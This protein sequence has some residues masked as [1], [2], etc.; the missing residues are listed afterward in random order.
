MVHWTVRPAHLSE[1]D[2]LNSLIYASARALS[3]SDYSFQQIEGLLQFVFGVDSELIHD[4]TYF[5]VEKEGVVVACG[6][7][8]KRRTLFGG[9]VCKTRDSGY[10]DPSKDAAKIRAFF[11][12]PDFSRQG[13][14]KLLI[15]HCEKAAKEFGFKKMELMSTVPGI[16]FY[17][18]QGYRGEQKINYTLPSGIVIELLPLYKTL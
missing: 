18:S 4:Q 7:W 12:H 17:Q 6:G 13:L 1:K 5:V 16:K 8:S 9:D 10:L 2:A 11:V 3:K 14:A 15:D